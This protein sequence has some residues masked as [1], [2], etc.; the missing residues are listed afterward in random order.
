M[1][2]QFKPVRFFVLMALMAFIA[3]GAVAFFTQRAAHGRTSEARAAYDSGLQ[4][5]KE[6]APAAKMPAAW[7][8]NEMAEKFM[9]REGKKKTEPMAWKTAFEHGYE[10][11]F[12]K[13]HPER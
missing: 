2:R 13:T 8:M 7:E 1:A 5:G 10:D 4:A 9:K 3:F 12:K 11:G 6:A